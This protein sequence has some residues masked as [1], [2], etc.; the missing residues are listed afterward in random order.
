MLN[1][2]NKTKRGE[3]VAEIERLRTEAAL[4]TERLKWQGEAASAAEVRAQNAEHK[5]EVLETDVANMLGTIRVMA[6]SSRAVRIRRKSVQDANLATALPYRNTE[7]L[8]PY[9]RR[10]PRL[11]GTCSRLNQC[12][13]SRP[14]L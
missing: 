7:Q 14:R 6:D 11:C 2:T 10:P 1:I 3:L 8:L 12:P 5:I 13:T 4:Q 9:R